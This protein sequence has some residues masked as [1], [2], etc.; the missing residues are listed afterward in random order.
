MVS[1][2]DIRISYRESKREQLDRQLQYFC[3]KDDRLRRIIKMQ[4]TSCTKPNQISAKAKLRATKLQSYWRRICE[5]QRRS[6]QRNQSILQDFSRI[7]SHLT[8]V[9]GKTERL[10]ILKKQYEDYIERTYPHWKEQVT[11]KLGQ[12]SK[13]QK[14]PRPQQSSREEY[15]EPDTERDSLFHRSYYMERPE[16]EAVVG[17]SVS[18]MKS[19]SERKEASDYANFKDVNRLRQMQADHGEPLQKRQEAVRMQEEQPAPRAA[20][21]QQHSRMSPSGPQGPP[22]PSPQRQTGPSPQMHLQSSQTLT[23]QAPPADVS[24]EEMEEMMSQPIQ[25]V[26]VKGIQGRPLEPRDTE[27]PAGISY[28]SGGMDPGEEDSELELED[29]IPLHQGHLA[30]PPPQVATDNLS[31]QSS[32]E[33]EEAP[34]IKASILPKGD[35][36]SPS[37]DLTVHGLIKLLKFVQSD[38]QHALSL[39][40]Y[41]KSH[42]PSPADRQKIIQKANSGAGLSG[43]DS[44][45]VSMVI[46]EQVTLVIRSLRTPCLLPD[47]ILTGKIDTISQTQIRVM[48]RDDAQPLWDALFEHLVLLVTCK[49]MSP[50]EVA[51]VF[52]P[53]MVSDK[54]PYQDKAFELLMKLLRGQVDAGTPREGLDSVTSKNH[55]GVEIGPDGKVTVPPLKFPGSLIDRSHTYNSDD[56]TSVMTQSV[57]SSKIPLNVPFKGKKATDAYKNMLSGSLSQPQ[58]PMADEE[59]DTDDDV[60]KQ[61]ASALSPRDQNI[62]A[63]I[64]TAASSKMIEEDVLSDESSTVAT[65]LYVPTGVTSSKAK[66]GL[67]TPRSAG[68]SQT[69]PKRPGFQ[70]QSD[71]DTDTEIDIL[72]KKGE[73]QEK[74]DEDFYDFYE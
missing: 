23:Q 74:E 13:S 28:S 54:S 14:L 27:S 49:I 68:L 55:S 73:D 16:E 63:T 8:A 57:T 41:Y 31:E 34:P 1:M 20:P 19:S 45:L 61:Y 30:S 59:E 47:S 67:T 71:L 9:S 5:D 4:G 36:Q 51:A 17:P 44:E 37:P 15:E 58:R 72:Q 3:K 50:N 48:L 53:C 33:E 60:E 18:P 56:D 35:R 65:P 22:S 26:T 11:G 10:R 32:P 24:V 2:N 38:F 29:N 39:D 69:G 70:F 40:G 21:S 66:S 64:P 25:S 42:P 46:L 6:Q 43:L 7:D 62:P 12:G 52:V